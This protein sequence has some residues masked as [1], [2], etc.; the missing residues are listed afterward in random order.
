MD[1][2]HN[3]IKESLEYL[4]Q[5][6]PYDAEKMKRETLKKLH[7]STTSMPAKKGRISMKKAW[8]LIAVILLFGMG[9]MGYSIWME[10]QT[11][12]GSSI[13][14]FSDPKQLVYQSEN[15]FVGKVVGLKGTKSLSEVPETQF[16][17]SVSKNIKGQLPKTVIVN[18]QK[19]QTDIPPL[20]LGKTYLFATR[21][22]V[23]EDWHTV[24][25]IY[26]EV[27]LENEQQIKSKVLEIEKAMQ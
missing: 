6:S 2:H 11:P 23:Q 16:E 7:L 9:W 20:V 12:S 21:H 18:Q 25:P 13:S 4:F 17:V 3:K 10:P 15:I 5:K 24:I 14:N 1:Q 26:G 8:S 27:L 22:L 19:I